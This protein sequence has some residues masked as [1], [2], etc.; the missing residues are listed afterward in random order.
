MSFTSKHYGIEGLK[1]VPIMPRGMSIS[2]R[3]SAGLQSSWRSMLVRQILLL[4]KKHFECLYKGLLQIFVVLFICCNKYFYFEVPLMTPSVVHHSDGSCS[5][6][7]EEEAP[8]KMTLSERFG[9]LAQVCWM[10]VV[11]RKRRLGR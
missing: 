7:E 8:R 3:R 9:K 2:F 10:G 6:S 11:F 1:G 4:P 5:S